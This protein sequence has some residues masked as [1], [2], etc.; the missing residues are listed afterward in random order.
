MNDKPLK[1]SL[2]N[3]NKEKSANRKRPD[4]KEDEGNDRNPKKSKKSGPAIQPEMGQQEEGAVEQDDEDGVAITIDRVKQVN[5]NQKIAQHANRKELL[6]AFELY[7]QALQEDLAN[8]HTFAA[9]VNAA[10][11]CAN[12]AMAEEVISTML[13]KGR[14]LKDVVLYTTL[15]KGYCAQG[16]LTKALK[17]FQDMRKK[18]AVVQPN[19]R[20]INTL[21]RGCVQMGE[22][23][24]AEAIF[25]QM[26]KE[27]AIK[28]DVSSWEYLITLLSQGLLV[29][30][31]L[32]INGRIKSDAT[33]QSGVISIN[34]NLARAAA[35]LGEYKLSSK[36]LQLVL[37]TLESSTAD[38]QDLADDADVDGD[39]AADSCSN[40][41]KTVMGGKR[42]WKST[43]DSTLSIDDKRNQ[44]LILYREHIREEWKQEAH[45]L[46]QFLQ[47]RQI[48][49]NK[50]SAFDFLYSFYFRILSFDSNLVYATNDSTGSIFTSV[51]VQ[52][53]I[54]VEDVR[55]QIFNALCYKF[56]L[57]ALVHK[58]SNHHISE[59]LALQ[60]GE[61]G[62][63]SSS[64]KNH[65]KKN[66][67]GKKNSNVSLA[68]MINFPPIQNGGQM[69]VVNKDT[70]GK[71]IDA[72]HSLKLTV[73]SYFDSNGFLNF[74]KIF[75][76]LMSDESNSDQSVHKPRLVKLEIC[77]GAG[78]WAVSQVSDEFH[79]LI[80]MFSNVPS[81]FRV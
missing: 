18:A 8:S 50:Q 59:L 9:M 36:C 70:S 23:Y 33:L 52:N 16:N 31:I 63:E 76:T 11:R 75:P 58:A 64:S 54:N 71:F 29:D 77:S 68:D 1:K 2:T 73:N 15:M 43:G 14:K 60:T 7:Q 41:Q 32:P 47:D 40:M 3:T 13:S 39:V 81:S 57:D 53:E 78:E 56:G 24:I 42:A 79:W 55:N 66:N 12:M 45:I 22:I 67:S 27:L 34:I 38:R 26:Q 48:S 35:L 17:L 44:S 65:G 6:Q 19:I 28:P 51:G 21:L 74:P 62:A 20:T 61:S 69:K 49:G 80:R 30:K 10:V 46:S 5:L 72:V 4:P 25:Q 37:T